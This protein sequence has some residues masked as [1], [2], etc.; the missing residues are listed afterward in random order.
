MFEIF[1]LNNDGFI[2]KDELVKMW[3]RLQGPAFTDDQ[4]LARA[5]AVLAQADADADGRLSIREF[6]TMV[7]GSDVMAYMTAI[8]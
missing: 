5:E 4:Y 8:A 6:S 7:S 1:D 3:K 2:D